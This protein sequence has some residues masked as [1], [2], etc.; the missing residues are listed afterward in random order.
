MTLNYITQNVLYTTTVSSV[1]FQ[2]L[3]LLFGLVLVLLITLLYPYGMKVFLPKRELKATS[4]TISN[5]TSAVKKEDNKCAVAVDDPKVT[6]K[7]VVDMKKLK[8]SFNLVHDRYK[9]NGL[10]AAHNQLKTIS[11]NVFDTDPSP[12]QSLFSTTTLLFRSLFKK[13]TQKSSTDYTKCY[14]TAT[15][16]RLNQF[17]NINNN[18]NLLRQKS[19]SLKNPSAATCFTSNLSLIYR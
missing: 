19:E 17:Q 10:L 9:V 6:V 15:A 2:D 14:K 16:I 13:M 8:V 7:H 4:K 18:Y 11:S 5:E 12:Q 3:E 1:P